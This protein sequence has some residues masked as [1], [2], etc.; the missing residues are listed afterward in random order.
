MLGE[1]SFR[2][3]PDAEY[4]RS[5]FVRCGCD[6]VFDVIGFENSEVERED[7]ELKWLLIDV[8]GTN[9]LLVVIV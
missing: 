5:L 8:V 2:K 3:S 7:K 4:L 6:I 1:A 9:D